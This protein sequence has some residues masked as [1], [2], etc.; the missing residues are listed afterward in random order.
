[1]YPLMFVKGL[2]TG[3]ETE[4]PGR[5]PRAHSVIIQRTFCPFLIRYIFVLF[6]IHP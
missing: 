5:V 4:F 1:M 6:V 2:T 3:Q